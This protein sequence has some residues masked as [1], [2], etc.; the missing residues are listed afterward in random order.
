[1]DN[2]QNWERVYIVIWKAVLS[3]QWLSY[4]KNVKLNIYLIKILQSWR[5]GVSLAL[6]IREKE[7]QL[8][9]ELE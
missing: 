9:P 7:R 3:N 5:V 4:E 6:E 8:A 2:V 1:M